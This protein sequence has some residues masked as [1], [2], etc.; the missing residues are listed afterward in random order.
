MRED[1]RE[2]SF[3]QR[4]EVARKR[5]KREDCQEGSSTRPLRFQV[6]VLLDTTPGARGSHMR[7]T[8]TGARGSDGARTEHAF[9]QRS[10]RR[11]VRTCVLVWPKSTAVRSPHCMLDSPAV[12][13]D[14]RQAQSAAAPTSS[15]ARTLVAIG[16]W[17]RSLGSSF[18]LLASERKRSC[19]GSSRR[20]CGQYQNG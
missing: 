6:S 13:D 18:D 4:R 10:S 2:G 20:F 15:A 5:L 16:S 9:T 17:L 1:S 19:R 11:I 12:L 7:T 14:T 3:E 8:P